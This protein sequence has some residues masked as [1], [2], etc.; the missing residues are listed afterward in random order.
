MLP[1]AKDES[2]LYVSCVGLPA[3]FVSFKNVDMSCTEKFLVAPPEFDPNSLSLDSTVL[4]E[5]ML[6][7]LGIIYFF[8][9]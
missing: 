9:N 2:Y 6:L 8:L 4:S 7:I 3:A 1:V 5:V